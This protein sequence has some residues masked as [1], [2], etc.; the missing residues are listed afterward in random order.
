MASSA[1][2]GSGDDTIDLS[3]TWQVHLDRSERADLSQPGSANDDRHWIPVELPGA[4]RDADI[5]DVVGPK[6]RWTMGERRDRLREPAYDK[7]RDAANFV[8]P[9]TWQ[10]R[11]RYV[12][13]AHYRRIVDVPKTWVGSRLRL[14]LERPHFRTAV[15]FDRVPLGTQESLST[16]HRY[17]TP[18]VER[19]GPHEILVSIDNRLGPLKIGI[20][21]HSIS[22]HT[23]TAWHGVIGNLRLSRAGSIRV[24]DLQIRSDVMGGQLHVSAEV[25]REALS[26]KQPPV[27]MQLRWSIRQRNVVVWSTKES[28]AMHA[29]RAPLRRTF[30]IG[31]RLRPWSEFD[32]ELYELHLEV[33][34][35]ADGTDDDHVAVGRGQTSFGYR[36][37]TAGQSHLRI[38]NQPVHLRGTLDCCVFP[39][40]GYPPTDRHSWTATMRTYRRFGLNHIRFH[41]W[42]PPKA[43]FEAADRAGMYLQVECA[44]WTENQTPL[45]SDVT[46]DSFLHDEADAILREYGNHPSFVMISSGNEPGGRDRG[47]AFLTRWVRRLNAKE[48]RVL[49]SGA[50]GWPAVDGDDYR[51]DFRPRLHQWGHG[52]RGWLNV[53]GGRSDFD[54][55]RMLGSADRPVLSHEV[56][57][58]CVFPRLAEDAKY[59]GTL[60]AGHLQ[61]LRDRLSQLGLLDRA[62][63]Y[64][65]ASGRLQWRC[66]KYEVETLLRSRRSAGFQMLGL[67]DFPGQGVAPV[68]VCDVFLDPKIYAEPEAFRRFCSPTVPLARW[69]RRNFRGGQTVAIPLQVYH[70]GD[71]ALE[72][73]RV[74]Y[75]AR[76]DGEIFDQGT[77]DVERLPRSRVTPVGRASITLP[78]VASARQCRLEVRVTSKAT[79]DN[80]EAVD[81]EAEAEAADQPVFN[82]PSRSLQRFRF[83]STAK[84]AERTDASRDADVGAQHSATPHNGREV[85][86]ENDWAFWVYPSSTPEALRSVA[87]VYPV[88]IA[89][90]LDDETFRH[91]EAGGRA[92]VF[93]QPNRLEANVQIGFAPIFWNTVWTNRQP[94]HSLWILCQADHP[95]L[96]DFPT[97][98]SSDWQWSGLLRKGRGLITDALPIEH[99]SIVD[100]IPDW[101]EPRRLSL[102][103]EAKTGRG[104]MLI[105]SLPVGPTSGGLSLPAEAMQQSLLN[106]ASSDRFEPAVSLTRDQL[107]T[108]LRPL[109]NVQR[110]GGNVSASSE[111][112]D[113]PASYAIDGDPQTIWHTPWENQTAPPPHSLTIDLGD[114]VSVSGV[115]CQSRADTSNARV[116]VFEIRTSVDGEHFELR[117]RGE[118]PN[119]DRVQ[120]VVFDTTTDARYVRFDAIDEYRRYAIASLAELDVILPP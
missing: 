55:D 47:Q 30:D 108:M 53:L 44:S 24:E 35:T 1:N 66:Y 56:G 85:H 60:R 4:L 89:T 36:T 19:G 3:G 9:F 69:N 109:T 118:M 76:D 50:T 83:S 33:R 61:I 31:E 20:N 11:R 110:M 87:G 46:V 102:L 73:V 45:G 93:C 40:T 100:V 16:P 43:A 22:D 37:V 74:H 39:K 103:L 49:V 7:F 57:Q 38:N 32:P 27:G 120:E 51:V 80:V 58:W 13:V 88:K 29:D 112:A 117:H 14:E 92:V 17:H 77:I 81:A 115:R 15:R 90:E 6:T 41:S 62:E 96:A 28:L 113:H 25:H 82:F 94:P 54:Y 8:Y 97:D 95:A 67:A 12:G 65:Q 111:A 84:R 23:Q 68:G 114:V 72:N 26:G 119:S 10:P 52:L 78:E 34:S 64:H 106:Y 98:S 59:T 2:G 107:R 101:H 99:G 42:C 75:L 79:D 105:T 63:A 70:F 48:D 71:R 21:A 18:I 91:V 116:R 104:K 5:G 86:G